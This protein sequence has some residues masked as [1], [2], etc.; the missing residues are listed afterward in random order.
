MP[1]ARPA[2]S[3]RDPTC[4]LIDLLFPGLPV[5]HTETLTRM[6]TRRADISTINPPPQFRGRVPPIGW[7]ACSV[8]NLSLHGSRFRVPFICGRK[9]NRLRGNATLSGYYVISRPPRWL[10]PPWYVIVDVPVAWLARP[11]PAQQEPEP[12]GRVHTSRRANPKPTLS[13]P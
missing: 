13:Q 6:L 4:F 2:C 5:P 12:V 8:I 9:I 1:R 3:R 10:R 11:R 7:V